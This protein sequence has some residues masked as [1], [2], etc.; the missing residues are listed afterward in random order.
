MCIWNKVFEIGSPKT[1]TTSLGKAFELLGFRHKGWDGELLADIRDALNIWDNLEILKFSVE[2]WDL[3]L[4]KSWKLGDFDRIIK[5]AEKYDAFEDGPWHFHGLFKIFDK[6]FPGSKFILLERDLS[7]W[8]DSH[9]KHFSMECGNVPKKLRIR[10]WNRK[11]DKIVAE[12]E[13]RYLLAKD[14]FADRPQDFLVMNVCRGEGL[15][16]LCDFLNVQ[17]PE[18]KFPHLNK[19]E[20]IRLNHQ[21]HGWVSFSKFLRCLFKK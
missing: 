17:I 18:N 8:L 6:Q 3:Y 5:E 9:K 2:D 21:S 12:H 4:K 10:D 14:Y 13:R 16:K 15:E 20:N 1:G 11:K 7:D 19:S